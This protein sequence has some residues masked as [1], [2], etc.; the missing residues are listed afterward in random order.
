MRTEAALKTVYILFFIFFWG[1]LL[2]AQNP[3]LMSDDGG[4]MIAASY[5]LGICHPP[6]YPLFSLIGRLFSY[7][8]IGSMAFRFNLM[9]ALFTFL[10]MAILFSAC[11]RLRKIS[12]PAIGN[13]ERIAAWA[14]SFAAVATLFS[15]RSVFAQSM[16]AKGCVYTL[17]LL[18]LAVM[19]WM[20]IQCLGMGMGWKQA[21]VPTFLW[22][23]GMGNHWQT[24][25]LWAPFFGIWF[26]HE[27][28][29][30][31]IKQIIVGVTVI[32]LGLSIYLYLPLRAHLNCLPS[33]GDPTNVSGFFWCL[34]RKPFAG[35]EPLF[36][37]WYFYKEFAE[38]YFRLA[39]FY[40]VPG[41]F[42]FV[43][44]GGYYLWRISQQ[45]FISLAFLY[46]PIVL[47]ILTVPREETLF[48][49]NVYLV[50]PGFI[51]ALLGFLGFFFIYRL[52]R[53]KGKP[54]VVLF[55][56]IVLMDLFLWMFNMK[57]LED[58]SR[59]LL[60]NDFGINVLKSIPKNSVFL[61]EGDHYVMPILYAR[62]AQGL[63]KDI[64]FCPSIFLFHGW[65]WKQ[66]GQQDDKIG[67]AING[68]IT[69]TGKLKTLLSERTHR[70][71][72]YS[73]DKEYLNDKL[74]EL[75]CAWA[76]NGLE[77]REWNKPP[78]I[79]EVYSGTLRSSCLERFRGFGEKWPQVDES[80]YQI[81]RYY[82]DQF[83]QAGHWLFVN[84][85]D[86]K[87]LYF[88]G[89]GLN[90]S[91]PSALN[92][93]AVLFGKEA[94]YKLARRFCVLA[95]ENDPKYLPS[96][97]NLAECY[98]REGNYPDAID[99]YEKAIELKPDDRSLIERLKETQEQIKKGLQPLPG[100]KTAQ[101]YRILEDSFKKMGLEMLSSMATQCFWDAKKG[102]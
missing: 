91:N 41:F 29:K 46:V 44:L 95:M 9:S 7:L 93:L 43:I 50:S 32:L 30:W 24:L 98:K 13:Q 86:A 87:A 20:R 62:F 39:V 40:W 65:G 85:A 90:I 45:L 15:C 60:A 94:Y 31:D 28:T 26:L 64:V 18:F 92:D 25:V 35:L 81:Y 21:L 37:N 6:G 8:P 38:Q 89:K 17:T 10:S 53:N 27:K 57:P 101:D 61:A 59:Y 88:L 80:T 70:A 1:F 33:W 19:V 72:L 96:Y 79:Q 63:R 71:F 56:T 4:E 5:N 78:G 14:L 48:L 52:L 55:F 23:I 34:S 73:L 2:S 76:P 77:F 54:I 42:F 16:T 3:G 100:L 75:P 12:E 84:G 66:L 97:I 47:G 67:A 36:R 82:Y 51:W 102:G 22:S 74:G 11:L 83:N 49:I 68:E 69:F 99:F 58:R